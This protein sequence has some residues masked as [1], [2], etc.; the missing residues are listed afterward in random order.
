[1]CSSQNLI[2]PS[3]GLALGNITCGWLLERLRSGLEMD[4]I[5]AY[6]VVIFAYAGLGI[7]KL[8]LTLFLSRDC[9]MEERKAHE[10]S[11]THDSE[12]T[13]L[14]PSADEVP[15]PSQRLIPTVSKESASV[16]TK[17]CLLFAIDSIASGLVPQ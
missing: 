2:V 11:V 17:L 14:L 6:R 12:E 3:Q 5:R 13:P 4:A 8:F 9:E 1:M 16:L 15:K 7:C 10:A